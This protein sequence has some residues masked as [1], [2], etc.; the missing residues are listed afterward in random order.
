MRL[1]LNSPECDAVQSTVLR[2]Q[3]FL[4]VIFHWYCALVLGHN[5]IGGPIRGQ[6]GC[7][8]RSKVLMLEMG[9]LVE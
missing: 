9:F 8:G 2:H 5:D 4:P 7:L 1:I 6:Y 3:A